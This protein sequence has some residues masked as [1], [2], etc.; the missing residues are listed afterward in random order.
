MVS[1]VDGM[2]SR[3]RAS[4]AG[5]DASGRGLDPAISRGSS[6]HFATCASLFLCADRFFLA[7]FAR[8]LNVWA[9]TSWTRLAVGS[10]REPDC[11]GRAST[12]T[13]MSAMVVLTVD[14]VIVLAGDG[15]V[16]WV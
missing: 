1:P 6:S 7:R 9:E 12:N 15:V 8:F 3:R 11:G 4:W 5:V 16:R 13:N 14:G 10:C 2:F